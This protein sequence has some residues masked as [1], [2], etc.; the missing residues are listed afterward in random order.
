MSSVDVI[1]PCYRYGHFLRECVESVLTQSGPAVRVLIID[2]ASPDNTADVA[3]DLA[4]TD[5]RVTFRR[6]TENKGHIATYN[7]GIAW[8]SADYLLLISADDYLLPDALKRAAELMDADPAVGF[9]FGKAVDLGEGGALKQTRTTANA[10]I[11]SLTG[12][13]TSRILR[14]VQFIASV[15]ANGS[16]NFVRTPTAV[17]RTVLQKGLGGYRPELPHSGDWE[18]W[19]RLSAHSAVG[20]LSAYQAVYRV[21]GGNMQWAYYRGARLADLEQRQAALECFFESCGHV[22][23]RPGELRARLLMPLARQAVACASQAFNDNDLATSRRLGQF[24][25]SAHPGV[26]KSLTWRLLG[27]KALLGPRLSRLLLRS[28]GR[29]R[30]AAVA[31][32]GARI[33]GAEGGKGLAGPL[34]ELLTT[35]KRRC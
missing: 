5:S 8:A 25:E 6:H 32:E 33:L 11:D 30:R 20:V 18:M 22:L 17:V 16:M 28:V 9:T 4:Y 27:C 29:L 7:E 3:A 26:R 21:H 15:E 14:G 24:A 35:G 19:L 23:P 13:A 10:I 1:V 31:R 34:R 2:D 12:D